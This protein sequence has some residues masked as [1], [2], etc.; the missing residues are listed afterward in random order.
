MHLTLAQAL[1]GTSTGAAAWLMVKAGTAKRALRLRAPER[2]PSCGRHR[3]RA[4]CR[5]T[6]LG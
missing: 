1:A 4:A 3:T 6:R 5:C 2:C